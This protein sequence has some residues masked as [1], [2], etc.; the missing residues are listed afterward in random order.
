MQRYI[1]VTHDNLANQINTVIKVFLLIC[2]RIGVVVEVGVVGFA[3]L[4]HA[5]KR[6]K[7][8]ESHKVAALIVV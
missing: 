5:V 7:D 8:V 1:P 3:D 4:V 2:E 6:V